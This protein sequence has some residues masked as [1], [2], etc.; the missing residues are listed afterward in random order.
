MPAEYAVEAMKFY[1]YDGTNAEEIRAALQ[2]VNTDPVTTAHANA[3][4]TLIQMDQGFRVLDFPLNT[5]DRIC[6]QNLVI[7]TQADWDAKFVKP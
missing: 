6:I 4:E 3:N 2:E 5:G 1:R 7:A